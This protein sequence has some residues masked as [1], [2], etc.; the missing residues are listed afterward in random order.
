MLT[1]LVAVLHFL[2]GVKEEDDQAHTFQIDG[3]RIGVSSCNS[4]DYMGDTHQLVHRDR[5]TLGREGT[6]YLFRISNGRRIRLPERYRKRQPGYRSQ[7]G[8][9]CSAIPGDQF[10]QDVWKRVSKGHFQPINTEEC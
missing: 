4:F 2:G 6:L 5:R 9:N 7:A 1:C 3:T 10:E 8:N